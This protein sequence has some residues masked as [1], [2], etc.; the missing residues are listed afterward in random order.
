MLS[1]P[2]TRLDHL[3]SGRKIDDG[4]YYQLDKWQHGKSDGELLQA[5]ETAVKMEQDR[6]EDRKKKVYK[7]LR[8][9]RINWKDFQNL[10]KNTDHPHFKSMVD[11]AVGNYD[12][13]KLDLKAD[14]IKS[15]LNSNKV[16]PDVFKTLLH[17]D[18]GKLAE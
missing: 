13:S 6:V 4:D 9:R 18:D 1:K 5:I 17:T 15:L 2:Q 11:D 7:E 10:C 12:P 3:L 16:G 8:G 14:Y